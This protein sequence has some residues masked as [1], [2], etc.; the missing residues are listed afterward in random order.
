MGENCQAHEAHIQRMKTIEDNITELRADQ[1]EIVKG[2]H[3]IR[4]RTTAT[5]QSTRSAHHRLD[6]QEEQT[7]AIYE[8]AYEV[9]S[10]GTK[11]EQ[12]IEQQGQIIKLLTDHDDR[13]VN[14]ETKDGK[15]ALKK[16]EWMSDQLAGGLIGVVMTIIGALVLGIIKVG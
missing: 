5:E 9:K 16:N 10:F 6:T 7:K 8:L 12:I 11:Q 2:C 3:E 4:E 1:R 15:E 13:I 14:L